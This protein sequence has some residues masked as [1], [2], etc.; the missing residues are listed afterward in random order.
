MV[1]GKGNQ[2]EEKKGEFVQCFS[3]LIHILLGKNKKIPHKNFR[4]VKL[5]LRKVS[6][7]HYQINSQLTLIEE[8]G[9]AL[10]NQEHQIEMQSLI[11]KEKISI[12]IHIR[13]KHINSKHLPYFPTI[14]AFFVLLVCIQKQ[15]DRLRSKNKGIDLDP[16]PKLYENAI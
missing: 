12:K 15:R 11:Y 3:F 2:K 10:S 5:Q 6:L 16:K 9:E 8:Q 13:L 7:I 4:Q 14:P 1:S